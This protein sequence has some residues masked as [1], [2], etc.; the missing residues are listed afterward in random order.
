MKAPQ[1]EDVNNSASIK[2][3]DNAPEQT[4]NVTTFVPGKDVTVE[5]GTAQVGKEL[6][7]TISYK[8]TEKT[9]QPL[10]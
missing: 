6:T 10:Y 1:A 9:P 3:G 7:Y 4:N 2:V 8:N 5:G